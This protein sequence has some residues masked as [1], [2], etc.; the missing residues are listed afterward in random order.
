[1]R[2]LLVEDEPDASRM[3]A[4][5]FVSRHTPSIPSITER[6]LSTRRASTVTIW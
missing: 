4:K 1:V 5:A 2:I 6:M 3:L